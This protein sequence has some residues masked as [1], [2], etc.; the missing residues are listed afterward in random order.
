MIKEVGVEIL[1]TK[2]GIT[3]CCHD[4]ENAFLDGEK[5]NIKGTTTKVIHNDFALILALLVQPVSD[6]RGGRFVHNAKNCQASNNAGILG[7]LALSI[8][9]ISR[10]RNNCMGDFLAQICFRSFLHLSENHG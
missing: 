7:G 9:E 5:R 10:H 4:F 6:S 3:S 8:I 2:M 1:T